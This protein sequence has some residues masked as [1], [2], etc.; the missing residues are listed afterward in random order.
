MLAGLV[1][2]KLALGY[3]QP[4]PKSWKM[5]RLGAEFSGWISPPSSAGRNIDQARQAAAVAQPV[6]ETYVRWLF[7]QWPVVPSAGQRLFPRVPEWLF[8]ACT[9]HSPLGNL[10]LLTARTTT[11]IKYS[12]GSS[13]T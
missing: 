13:S 12:V 8:N 3:L 1:T 10:V 6:T 5:I 2:P 4:L 7:F 9:V 11:G